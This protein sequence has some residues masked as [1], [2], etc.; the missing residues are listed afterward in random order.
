MA[1]FKKGQKVYFDCNS[2]P[3]VSGEYT[4]ETDYPTEGFSWLRHSNHEPYEGEL[5]ILKE[6]PEQIVA[7]TSLSAIE[8]DK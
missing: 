3:A 4:I 2:D 5:Y 8:D 6:L 7:G 1:E